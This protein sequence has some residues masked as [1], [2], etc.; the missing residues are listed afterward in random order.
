[1]KYFITFNK[2]QT[3]KLKQIKM[4][5]SNVNVNELVELFDNL[6]KK[7]M[8]CHADFQDHMN[9]YQ[10]MEI[11]ENEKILQ[12]EKKIV[13]LNSELA[14]SET[15]LNGILLMGDKIKELLHISANYDVITE[16]E[17]AEQLNENQHKFQD[18][19][20]Y[21]MGISAEFEKKI[22]SAKIILE[23]LRVKKESLDSALDLV[24]EWWE[25][26]TTI[27]NTAFN[28]QSELKDKKDINQK[29]MLRTLKK[30]QSEIDV[31]IQHIQKFIDEHSQRI[32]YMEINK[33][34]LE[35]SRIKIKKLHEQMDSIKSLG[36]KMSQ[37]ITRFFGSDDEKVQ[38][39]E[40]DLELAN[41]IEPLQKK[42]EKSVKEVSEN[43]RMQ[44]ELQEINV[45]NAQTIVNYKNV[46]IQFTS[47]RDLIEKIILKI[48]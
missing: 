14:L 2:I 27:V 17:C 44:K 33:R 8:I 22:E 3:N 13:S 32:I 15:Q 23:D 19:M 34:D 37:W 45:E 40:H 16:E 25:V 6:L 36:G 42:I 35:E 31:C 10:I 24:T 26:M 5:S 11:R 21:Q 7:G 12:Y 39:K 29:D 41:I 28:H 1:M 9:S 38:Q 18:I 43:E 4:N 30:L 46:I 47:V 48:E 20:Q